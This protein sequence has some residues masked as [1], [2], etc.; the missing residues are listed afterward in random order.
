MRLIQFVQLWLSEW[1]STNQMST[2]VIHCF[3]QNQLKGIIRYV[4]ALVEMVSVHLVC[5]ILVTVIISKW[6]I[7]SLKEQWSKVYWHMDKIIQI[8]RVQE[9]Y[10]KPILK[11]FCTRKVTMKMMLIARVLYNSYIL[12]KILIQPIA[13]RRDNCL[14]IKS[15]AE[16]DVTEIA[17]QLVK[18]VK[19]IREQFSSSH[20]LEVYRVP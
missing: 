20:I 11:I 13:K 1:V 4:I 15:L 6:D 14:K 16:N 5:C 3:F 18:F 19:L 17:K 2:F 7:W 9:R 12:E 10:W 8:W